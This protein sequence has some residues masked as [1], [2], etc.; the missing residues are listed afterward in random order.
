MKLCKDHWQKLREAIDARG[1][2][3]FVASSGE[4]GMRKIT[5]PGEFEPLM[6]AYFALLLNILAVA[7]QALMEDQK[8]GPERCPYCFLITSHKCDDPE[9]DVYSTWIDRAADDAL[10]AAVDLGLLAEV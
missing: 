4:E 9:C 1:L 5:T 7:G 6:H 2:G 8:N 3:K 10:K